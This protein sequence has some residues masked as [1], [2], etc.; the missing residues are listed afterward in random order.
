MDIVKVYLCPGD[1]ID[2]NLDVYFTRT[3][4]QL[5]D[6]GIPILGFTYHPEKGCY[7]FGDRDC[8]EAAFKEDVKLEDFDY[9]QYILNLTDDDKFWTTELDPYDPSK[10]KLLKWV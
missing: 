1:G 8:F 6:K 5:C 3:F 4:E 2:I 9:E 7:V 10:S